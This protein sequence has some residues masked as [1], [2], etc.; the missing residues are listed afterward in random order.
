[1][2]DDENKY[3]AKYLKL[4]YGIPEATEEEWKEFCFEL[5]LQLMKQ[6]KEILERLKERGDRN[7]ILC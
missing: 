4:K 3:K 6:N 2:R 1:M 7:E 5:L